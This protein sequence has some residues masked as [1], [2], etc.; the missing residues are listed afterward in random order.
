MNFKNFSSTLISAYLLFGVLA[1]NAKINCNCHIKDKSNVN[2][3]EQKTFQRPW[4]NYTVIDEG[5]GYL[6]K[7]ITVNV[8]LF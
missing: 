1:V 2:L 3:Q 7:T 6:I 8:H 5:T 4:G